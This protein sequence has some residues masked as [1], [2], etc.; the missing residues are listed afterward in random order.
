MALADLV[1]NLRGND[2]EETRDDS[3]EINGQDFTE[4]PD[5]KGA[6]PEGKHHKAAPPAPR[7]SAAMRKEVEDKLGA[8]LEFFALGWEQRDPYCAGKLDEQAE[9]IT[10][11]AVA[12]ICKRPAML[13]W[14]TESS[15][16]SDWLMLATALQPVTIAIWQHHVSKEVGEAAEEELERYGAP[17]VPG[18]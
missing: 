9:E 2:S 15:D 16:W 10:K 4:G 14:F 11:R 7:V 12:I 8:M 3:P 6:R 17:A 18:T 13:R 5:P 1:G